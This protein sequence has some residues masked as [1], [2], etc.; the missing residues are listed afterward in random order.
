MSSSASRYEILADLTHRIVTT[1]D[2]AS[3]LD[4]VVHELGQ[5]LLSCCC[6]IFLTDQSED[7]LTLKATSDKS[8]PPLVLTIDDSTLV[9]RAAIT[10]QSFFINNPAAF[11]PA[12]SLYRANV[13]QAEITIPL[14]TTKQIYGVLVAQRDQAPSFTADDLAILKSVTHQLA[15]ALEN[16][17][18]LEDRD[19]RVAELV[20]FNQI[21]MIIAEHRDLDTI[22]PRTVQRIKSLFQVEGV[23]LLLLENNE[24]HF[25]AA[26]GA[27][28]EDLKTFTL[29]RGQGIAWSV[30]ESQKTIRVDDV[31]HDPRHFSDIDQAIEFSTQSL[32]AV[33]IQTPDRILGVLEAM[34]RLDGQPFSRDDEVTLEFIVSAVAVVIE[35]ARLFRQM[36]REMD[37][38]AGLLEAS[39]ALNTL[40]L[41]QILDTIV[42]KAGNLLEAE[43]TVVY[44]VNR[45]V[46]NIQATAVHSTG[47][48]V[49][50]PTPPFAF[51]QGTVGWVL[52]HNQ[53]LIINDVQQD[54]R[55]FQLTP[56][57]DLIVNLVTVPLVVKSEAIGAIEATHKINGQ[58]FTIEDEAL[59]AAFAGQAALAIDNAR[60]FKERG[61]RLAEVST[62]YTLADQI[63]KVLD[64]ERITS[65]T[66][67]ILKHALDC[68][69]CLVLLKEKTTGAE[70]FRLKAAAG[71]PED[72]LPQLEATYITALVKGLKSKTYPTYFKDI[73]QPNPD[74]AAF[75]MRSVM[76]VPLTAKNDVLGGLVICDA[77]PGAFG[78]AEGRLLTI[79]AAQLSKAIENISLYDNLEKRAIEL[80][81]VLKDLAEANQLKS[82]FVQNVSH[83]LR[84]PLTFIISYLELMLEGSLGEI[85]LP[86]F[87]KLEIVSQKTRT[88]I[89]LVEDI[90]S[91]QKIEAGNLQ[92]TPFA[93]QEII[94]RVTRGAVANAAQV[95]INIV[96]Q[97]TSVLPQVAVDI[98]R[99]EQVFDNL[100][101]NALKFSPKDSTILIEA[102]QIDDTVKFSVR[103]EGIGIP[104]PKL[105]KIFDRFYQV[106]GSI[107]RRYSGAGLGLAIIKQIVEAH[108]GRITVESVVNQGTIFTFWLP[109]YREPT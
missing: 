42:Q 105:D 91:L 99:I 30:I 27:G 69:G 8:L 23:S 108:G 103:D 84:T 5:H 49:G 7:S 68:T 74:E 13:L 40:D 107:T 36:Q 2:L 20:T 3:L 26:A 35:N 63:T 92:L 37:Y 64:L 82:E 95:G 29:K 77:R 78:Q 32:L 100:V 62:L 81:K 15:L 83:E 52:A 57:S 41:Q 56:Q 50:M 45:K 34:N 33:P 96:S 102:H 44:L 97:N 93:P 43:H 16:I 61:E 38:K 106:D 46:H 9:G 72:Q 88:I 59:L 98:D 28:A 14:S 85:P 4:H 90:I 86:V 22:L 71:W 11:D 17:G 94:N 87:E 39:R 60:L 31:K 104:A 75:P 54:R 79:T 89:R 47:Q 58:N 76:M 70:S 6:S 73:N 101:A 24:L 19:R 51:D 1:S 65:F 21:G 66:T 109:V 18:L 10:G 80:E 12:L 48:L 25:V 67:I 55:F 53:S